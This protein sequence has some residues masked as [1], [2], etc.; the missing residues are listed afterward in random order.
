ME[1]R[2]SLYIDRDSGLHRLNPL[3]K[4][5]IVAFVAVLGVLMPITGGSLIVFAAA[6]IPLA[7]WGKVTVPLLRASFKTILPFAISLLIVQGLFWPGGTPIASLG[8]IS[9]KEEGLLFAVR[10][11]GRILIIAS[12]IILLSLS[13]RPDALMQALTQ[14]GVPG[15][16]TYIVLTTIQIVP[17]FQARANTIMDAQRSRGLETEGNLMQ[18]ARAM[19]PLIAPLILGSLVDVEE[20][21]IALEVRAFGRSGAKTYLAVLDDSRSQVW[22]RRLLLLGIL[23]VAV[24]RIVWGMW[25]ERLP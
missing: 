8:P 16:I 3:T 2:F 1:S 5:A 7:A 23:V 12:S 14:R 20:R 10:S 15:S 11:A 6:V 9:L 22:L 19:V 24:A 4:L 21:A 18:R 25:G 17:R 13:T